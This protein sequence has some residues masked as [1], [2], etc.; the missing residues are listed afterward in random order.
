MRTRTRASATSQPRQPA[1]DLIGYQCS[2]IVHRQPLCPPGRPEPHRCRYSVSVDRICYRGAHCPPRHHWLWRYLSNTDYPRSHPRYQKNNGPEPV[3][4][5]TPPYLKVIPISVILFFQLSMFRILQAT[6]TKS[7]RQMCH[8]Q[9]NFN[10]I[11]SRLDV[12]ANARAQHSGEFPAV[13]RPD[14]TKPWALIWHK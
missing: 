11:L 4:H 7:S 13:G 5:D 9:V 14:I 6:A 3:T 12:Y 10:F 2:Q 8:C 1:T